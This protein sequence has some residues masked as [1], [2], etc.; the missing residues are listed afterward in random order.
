MSLALASIDP[1]ERRRILD[2]MSYT[3]A[4]LEARLSPLVVDLGD[5]DVDPVDEFRHAMESHMPS[6][7]AARSFE[8]GAWSIPGTETRVA[9]SC[10]EVREGETCVP[11]WSSAPRPLDR[12]RFA[13]WAISNAA[14][15]DLGTPAAVEAAARALRPRTS[16]RDSVV[17]LVITEADLALEE[18]PER[19]ALKDAAHRLGRAMAANEIED[20]QHLEA[21]ARAKP[22]GRASPWLR[23]SKTELVVV[24]RLSA[25]TH[26][27]ELVLEVEAAAPTA[28]IRWV[29]RP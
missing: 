17:S 23:L 7:T 9:A 21:F 1:A 6:F 19:P 24:P 18:V 3:A 12:A 20:D 16:A 27:H 29:N 22:V 26:L 8:R 15:V 10:A 2:D 4:R 25:L 5:E 28:H 11:L 13:S 14:V